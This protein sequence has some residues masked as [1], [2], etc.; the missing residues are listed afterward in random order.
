MDAAQHGLSGVA[1]DLQ[2]PSHDRGGASIELEMEYRP[3]GMPAGRGETPSPA[4][5]GVATLL[6]GGVGRLPA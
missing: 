6:R 1:I 3:R 5:R 2:M 4:R